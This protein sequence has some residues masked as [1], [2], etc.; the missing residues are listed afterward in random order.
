MVDSGGTLTGSLTGALMGILALASLVLIV[1]FI[2]LYVISAIGLS[3]IAEKEGH[4]K[5]WLAWIPIAN[6]FLMM[7]LVEDD[8][9]ESM[10]GK[11][12]LIFA[13]V[14]IASF[15]LSG[16]FPP[17]AIVPSVMM[18]YALYLI[19]NKRS[20]NAVMYL[21]ISVVTFNFATPF[22]LFRLR[23][24]ERRAVQVEDV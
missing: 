6:T 3:G 13:I 8:V 5:A 11:Y 20:E 1:V 17:I 4:D 14:F 7:M 18:Y 16:F 21:I 2:G 12:T 24:R 19:A 10:R 23:N 15:V 22:M 9:H